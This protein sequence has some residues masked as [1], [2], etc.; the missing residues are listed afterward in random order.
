MPLPLCEH[1][2]LLI[3]ET[4][5][6][7]MATD[8]IFIKSKITNG[9]S[10]NVSLLMEK[11]R[12]RTWLMRA[13]ITVIIGLIISTIYNNTLNQKIIN[14]QRAISVEQGRN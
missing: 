10:T 12:N 9:L 13:V 7:S 3:L 4:K 14:N 2:K 6:D 1:D 5:V 8:I 11:D